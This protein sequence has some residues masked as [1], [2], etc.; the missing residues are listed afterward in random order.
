[1]SVMTISGSSATSATAAAAPAAATSAAKSATTARTKRSSSRPPPAI[2]KRAESLKK[3]KDLQASD[4]A[5]LKA[6]AAEIADK[7]KAEAGKQG[8]EAGKALSALAD[9]FDTVARTGD[10]SALQPP[11]KPAAGQGGAAPQ[12]AEAYRQGAPGA[13][14][15]ADVAKIVSDA[16]DGASKSA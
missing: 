14:G 12:G 16:V 6:A 1:M 7:L 10:L 9:K 5:K 8:G 15:G 2:S 11:P 13:P 4:P 3:L